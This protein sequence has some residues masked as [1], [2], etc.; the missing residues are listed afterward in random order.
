MN[1]PQGLKAWGVFVLA[2]SLLT[3][4]A[5]LLL[6][7]QEGPLFF[8]DSDLAEVGD[9]LLDR[10]KPTEAA[11]IARF[12]IDRP[13]LGSQS[14]AE[15]ILNRS[16]AQR[17]NGWRRTQRVI[18]GAITG[19][20]RDLESLAGA[21][22]L[23]LFLLGDLRDIAIQGWRSITG[24]ET[25]SL[26]LALATLGILTSPTLQLDLAPALAKAL[27]RSGAFSASLSKELGVLGVKLVQTGD[28]P[29]LTRAMDD[30]GALTRNFGFGPLTAMLKSVDSTTALHR[31]TQASASNP[32]GTYTLIHLFGR[33]GVGQLLADGSQTGKTLGRIRKNHRFSRTLYKITHRLPLWGLFSALFLAV[34][35]LLKSLFL[36]LALI[37]KITRA[38]S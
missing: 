9:A 33:R 28:A 3:A 2:I 34:A 24:E 21:V 4:T 8:L 25:D 12:I 15:L 7:R 36:F 13:D 35:A 17:N 16:R 22:A 29:K 26:I 32:A 10:E 37:R 11:L 1:T 23:D 31:L 30:I 19:E 18:E 27:R 20:A 38:P 14:E 6:T 5:T